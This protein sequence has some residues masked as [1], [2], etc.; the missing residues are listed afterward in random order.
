LNSDL[1]LNRI[2]QLAIALIR[3]FWGAAEE[4]DSP[5]RRIIRIS[6]LAS[7]K[8]LLDGKEATIADVRRALEQAKSKKGPVWYYRESGKSEPPPQAVE[9]FKLIVENNLPISLS[10]KSDFSDYVDEKGQSHPRK[11][12]TL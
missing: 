1:I 9:V 11:W 10:M 6:S 8:I 12:R 7:G 5:R 4:A 3:S 2:L